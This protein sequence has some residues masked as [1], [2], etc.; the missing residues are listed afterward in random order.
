MKGEPR[1]N[2]SVVSSCRHH[3]VVVVLALRRRRDC[4]HRV[5]GATDESAF[6]TRVYAFTLGDSNTARRR[7]MCSYASTRSSPVAW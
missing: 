6:P 2:L 1:T 3:R 7:A 4:R 5:S